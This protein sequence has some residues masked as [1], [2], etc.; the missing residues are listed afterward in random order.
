MHSATSPAFKIAHPF[1]A[2]WEGGFVNHR[3]DPGGA[4]NFGITRA[5]LSAWRGHKVSIDDVRNLSIHEAEEIYFA[6]YW[7]PLHADHMPTAIA[8]MTYN[9]AVN[10][11]PSRGVKLLQ[12]ALNGLGQQIAVDGKVGQ[13][14]LTAIA[15]VDE[16]TLIAAYAQT[17]ENFYRRLK[18]F[19]T[20]GKGWLNR[21]ADITRGARD[22][23]GQS[24]PHEI[25]PI[26]SLENPPMN[27]MNI[28]NIP[29]QDPIMQLLRIL[30]ASHLQQQTIQ[31]AIAQPTPPLTP[32][33]NALGEAVGHLL[34]GRK[35]G[36][37][38]LGLLL[39]AILPIFF[40]AQLAPLGS[41]ISVLGEA[42]QTEPV[43]EIL[44]S[45]SALGTKIMTALQ[46]LLL[47]I[48]GW[49]VLGKMDKW[50]HQAQSTS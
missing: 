12:K 35:T 45:D 34:N 23:V 41:I 15:A 27:D 20:F 39:T 26:T 32:V 21:L 30:L 28:M 22:L 50:S 25:K 19:S 37:G 9:A 1:I 6:R 5:T 36:L 31:T 43:R 14:T 33:N 49:G 8:L 48:T 4:T 2:K 40:P 16:P 29:Q 3:K 10:S 46:P 13:Q 42:A 38:S 44:A 17:H 7:Q 24:I 11:G 47:G 18:H